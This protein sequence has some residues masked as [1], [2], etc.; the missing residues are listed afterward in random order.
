MKGFLKFA[1]LV[2]F[3]LV[4]FVGVPVAGFFYLFFVAEQVSVQASEPHG[5]S[6]RISFPASFVSLAL[7]LSK[8]RFIIA[9]RQQRAEIEAWKPAIRAAA[10]EISR[11]PD[12]PLI[13]VV[14]GRDHVRVVKEGGRLRVLVD[15]SNGDSVRVDIPARVVE[16]IIG[17]LSD[18]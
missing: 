10:D 1:A 4:L 5:D 16:R 15:S 12:I 9:S 14:D 11:H 6:I 2:A 8:P 18:L 7:G 17:D 13:E 3:L